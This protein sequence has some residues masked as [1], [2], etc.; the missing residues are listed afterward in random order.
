MRI[1]EPGDPRKALDIR[2]FKCLKCGCVF[3]AERGEYEF[4]NQLDPGPY[5]QCPCCGYTVHQSLDDEYY[6]GICK[7]RG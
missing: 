5:C 3:E 1:I 6:N 4:G 7:M 2:V